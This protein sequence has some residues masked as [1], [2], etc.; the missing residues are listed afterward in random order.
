MHHEREV[1]RSYVRPAGEA[2]ADRERDSEGARRREEID[3][4]AVDA[5]VSYEKKMGREPERMPHENEGFDLISTSA[6]GTKRFIEIKGTSPRWD[7]QG[8]ALSDRQFQEARDRTSEFWLYVVEVGLQ[9]SE[10]IRIQD[11]ATRVKQYFFDSGWRVADEVDA[12]SE[13]RLPELP[14]LED[15][16][17]PSS[18]PLCDWRD[19][20]MEIGWIDVGDAGD[21]LADTSAIQIAGEALGISMRGGVVL[22]SPATPQDHDW[23]VV[24][25]REQV[26]PDTGSTTCVRLWVPETDINNTLLGV[27]LQSDSAVPPITIE[28]PGD[29][30]VLGVVTRQLRIDALRDI[31]GTSDS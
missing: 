11:P 8:V 29:V 3:A 4:A 7:K 6:D 15:G 27:R 13:R 22:F 12:T 28:N 25:L 24:S 1:L 30:E 20:T 17:D 23:V 9:D 10:P 14:L 26:D 5:V 18:V 31:A 16:G 21:H 2:D 19:P